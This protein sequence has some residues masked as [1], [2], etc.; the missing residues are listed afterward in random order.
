M[1]AGI[2]IVTVTD[3]HNC[4]AYTMVQIQQPAL[5]L[6]GSIT[7]THVR[8]FGEG[9]GIADL[10]VFGGTP[11]YY[12]TWSNGEISED[13]YNLIPDI[14]YVNINDAHNCLAYDTVQIL[15][16]LVL[17][18]EQMLLVTAIPMEIFTFRLAEDVRLT[19]MYGQREAGNKI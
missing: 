15:Q 16:C 3:A 17:L 5:P 8:C 2:Y 12:F 18:Q 13:I 9:N 11:P 14:Y 1:Y 4:V 10:N 19:L 6:H 7:P